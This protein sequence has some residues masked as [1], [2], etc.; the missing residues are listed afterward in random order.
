MFDMQDFLKKGDVFDYGES[1]KAK[2]QLEPLAINSNF[3]IQSIVTSCIQSSQPIRMHGW[4]GK[5]L[6]VKDYT[7]NVDYSLTVED[8]CEVNNVL[9]V[10]KT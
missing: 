5:E 3:A 1:G 6:S 7:W 4:N 2:H 9:L 10:D 8:D